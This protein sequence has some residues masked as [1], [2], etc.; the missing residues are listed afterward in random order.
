M[1]FPIL[2]KWY[3]YTGSRPSLSRYWP[4]DPW[5][6]QAVSQPRQGMV[7]NQKQTLLG[8][9]THSCFC[10]N[11]KATIHFFNSFFFQFK[12]CLLPYNYSFFFQNS[13]QHICVHALQIQQAVPIMQTIY[14][15]LI[16][17]HLIQKYPI[18]IS[19]LKSCATQVGILQEKKWI[20]PIVFS[21]SSGNPIFGQIFGHQ[22]VENEARNTKM[23]RGQ[24]THPTR[25][26]ARYEMNW[27]NSF[28][29]NFRKPHFWPNIW[30]PEGRKWG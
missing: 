15:A 16:T 25:I 28:F 3:L 9:G 24:E 12:M 8:C 17:T 4:N 13:S 1:G 7:C 30:P 26:N 19:I 29:K 18:K 20:E 10:N 6:W 2:L 27:A 14:P 5:Q 23:Y 22:R 21:K 11:V